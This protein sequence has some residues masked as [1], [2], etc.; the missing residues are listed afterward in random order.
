MHVGRVPVQLVLGAR[1]KAVLSREVSDGAVVEEEEAT[2]GTEEDC[3]EEY[4]LLLTLLIDESE[5]CSED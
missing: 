1:C 2:A 5:L 4:K 3:E